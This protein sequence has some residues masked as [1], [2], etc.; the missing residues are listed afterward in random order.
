[1]RELSSSITSLHLASQIGP[2]SYVAF[3]L[4]PGSHIYT[5]C[6]AVQ[7]YR[8]EFLFKCAIPVKLD[9]EATEFFKRLWFLL[10]IFNKYRSSVQFD[11][12]HR[13]PQGLPSIS[14][15]GSILLGSATVPL[16]PLLS[17]T[18]G[19]WLI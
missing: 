4:S 9:A 12:W 10:N 8:P 15:P 17:S 16:A 18:Q 2:N 7:S 5:T 13:T 1:M 6:V 11:I 19:Q 3:S 14:R